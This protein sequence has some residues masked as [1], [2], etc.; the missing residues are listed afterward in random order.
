MSASTDSIHNAISND[1][2]TY[3]NRIL[4]ALYIPVLLDHSKYVSNYLA[5]GINIIPCSWL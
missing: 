3:I 4:A 5:V 1:T 2:P